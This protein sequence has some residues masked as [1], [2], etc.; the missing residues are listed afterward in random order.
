MVTA[1]VDEELAKRVI[2]LGADDYI[3]KPIDLGF[4]R[5]YVLVRMIQLLN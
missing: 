3:V 4:L 5:V 2:Q 1:V